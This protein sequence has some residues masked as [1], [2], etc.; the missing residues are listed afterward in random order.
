M[1]IRT[2]FLLS[3]LCHGLFLFGQ[4]NEGFKA[5]LKAGI[6]TSQMTGDGYAGF[7]KFSP[8]FGAF[9]SHGLSEK[10]RFQYEIIYQTKGSRD[11]ANPEEGKYTS[12]KITLGYI[13]VP[14][15]WQYDL[16]KRLRCVHQRPWARP[17][18]AVVGVFPHLERW[19]EQ[20]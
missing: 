4:V 2:I 20:T 1:R 15:L 5:G 7:Y 3:F 11:P 16:K 18:R 9:A 6:N 13:S 14:L 10:M 19:L 17:C 8:V 12:Y